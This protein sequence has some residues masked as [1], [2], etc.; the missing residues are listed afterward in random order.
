MAI[1]IKVNLSGSLSGQ[2]DAMRDELERSVTVAVAAAAEGVKLDLRQQLARGARMDKFRKAIQSRTWP[3]PP[4][5]SADAAGTVFAAGEAADKAFSAFAAGAI[6]LPN[7]AK[8]LA[9]PLHGFRGVD[10]RLL[11]PTSSYFGGVFNPKSNPG[12]RLHYIPARHRAASTVGIL[13]TRAAGRPG[14]IRKQLATKGRARIADGL[15]GAWIPQFIL[16]RAARLPK[17]LTLE[18]TA[19]KWADQLPSLIGDALDALRSA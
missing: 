9:I 10:G 16:V 6:V 17:L 1:A 7:K 14:E 2:F 8:A 3:K 5:Y 19:Q 12:G 11:G 13:A 18:E 4:R 15:V